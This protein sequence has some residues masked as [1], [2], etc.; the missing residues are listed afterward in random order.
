MAV[1]K[2]S[3]TLA[4]TYVEMLSIHGEHGLYRKVIGHGIIRYASDIKA[5]EVEILDLAEA[6]FS[7]YRRGEDEVFFIIGRVLRRAAHTLYRKLHKDTQ[8][9]TNKRF[10]NVVR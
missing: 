3:E 9:A 8:T 10:L 4:K 5:P 6:F 7:A 2:L 1:K